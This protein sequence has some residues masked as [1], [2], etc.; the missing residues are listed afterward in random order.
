MLLWHPPIWQQRLEKRNLVAVAHCLP[1]RVHHEHSVLLWSSKHGHTLTMG[2]VL[3]PQTRGWPP[4]Q[5]NIGACVEASR[6][7][8]GETLGLQR[9][10]LISK[11][12]QNRRWRTIEKNSEGTCSNPQRIIIYFNSLQIDLHQSSLSR[13]FHSAEFALEI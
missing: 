3:P 9:G 2:I 1:G 4:P 11:R 13:R 6:R 7:M 5:R 8:A 10:R 12:P